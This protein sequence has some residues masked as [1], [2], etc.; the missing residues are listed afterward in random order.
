MNRLDDEID[1]VIDVVIRMNG[2]I[3]ERIKRLTRGLECLDPSEATC[4]GEHRPLL[5]AVLRRGRIASLDGPGPC[6]QCDHKPLLSQQRA[7]FRVQPGAPACGDH[8]LL[9]RYR[10]LDRLLFSY[11]ESALPLRLKNLRD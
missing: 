5:G 8:D 7:I 3:G 1:G 2:E 4:P 10:F 6:L 11:A 9:P